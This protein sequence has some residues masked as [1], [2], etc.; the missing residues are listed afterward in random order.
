MDRPSDASSVET[1]AV[2]SRQST[3]TSSFA[4]DGRFLPGTLLGGRYRIIALLGA[5]RNWKLGRVDRHGAL[6][7]GS[8]SCLLFVAG[9]IGDVHA[10]PTADIAVLLYRAAGNWLL[11]GAMLA[12]VYLALEAAVRARWPHSLMTWNRLLAGRWRDPQVAS[13]VLIGGAVGCAVWVVFKLIDFWTSGGSGLSPMESLFFT[14]GPRQWLGG[15]AYILAN[16]V[17]V[18]LFGFLM[19]CGLRALVRNALLAAVV[20]SILFTFAEGSVVNSQHWQIRA[21]IYLGAYFVIAFVLLRFGLVATIAV[22]FFVNA[23]GATNLG[24]DWKT[25]YAP[26]GLASLALLLSVALFAFWKSLGV[27]TAETG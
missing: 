22:I 8:V 4:E 10:I 16:A 26:S 25:W 23:I 1:V 27:E 18:G 21:A 3:S 6:W 24:L 9:W 19:I 5:R 12:L 2:V 15:F 13:H 11:Y 17:R 20:A 14:L 7:V